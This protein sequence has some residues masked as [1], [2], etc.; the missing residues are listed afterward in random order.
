MGPAVARRC[1]LLPLLQPL[2]HSLLCVASPA[3][4]PSL[5]LLHCKHVDGFVTSDR[6]QGVT[7]L[8]N[9]PI[10]Q[11]LTQRDSSLQVATRSV[12]SAIRPST[13]TMTYSDGQTTDLPLAS[14][15]EACLEACQAMTP[16]IRSVYELLCADSTGATLKKDQSFFSLADGI[17][18]Q[19]LTRLLQPYVGCI[20]GEE[21]S[22]SINIE[23]A[24]FFAGRLR[25][26][27]CEGS[28]HIY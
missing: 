13:I 15:L 22:S 3:L 2:S 21:D 7:G 8:L 14:L 1:L 24:P 10:P 4:L 17:V 9:S 27:F 20:V 23:E 19:L 16:F 5:L 26:S 12:S 11:G 25:A 6:L 28:Q 18:Q